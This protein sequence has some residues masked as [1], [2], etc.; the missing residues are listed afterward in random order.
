MNKI[1]VITLLAL[2]SACT[3]G[4][5]YQAPDISL[6]ES[7]FSYGIDKPKIDTKEAVEQE[8]WHHFNDPVLDKLI[9]KANADN[10]DLKI[11]TARIAESR[12]GRAHSI[13]DFLPTG[14][15][16]ASGLREGNQIAFPQPIAGLQKPF[17]TFQTGFDA[18]WE[19]DVFGKKKRALE[20]SSAEL[21]SAEATA[22]DARISIL[23]EVA[24]TYIDIRGY[25]ENLAITAENISAAQKTVDI[26]GEQY[27]AGKISQL[28]LTQAKAQL[29]QA[30]TQLPYYQNLLAQAEY[31]MDLLLGEQPNF[32]HQ[33]LVGNKSIPVFDKQ[34]VLSAPAKIIANRPDI[35]IAE[36]NLAAATANQGVAI[37]QFF[38]DISLSGFIG[39][40]NVDAGNMLKTSSKSWNAGGNILLPILNYGKLSANLDATDAKQ[41]QELANYQK[42]IISA[43]SDVAKSMTAYSNQEKLREDLIK[44]V[45]E[46]QKTT[47]IA[48]KR[49][50][51]GASSFTDVLEAKR[52]L[53]AAEIQ[54]VQ[55]NAKAAQNLIAV[56]KSLGG[57]WKNTEPV[58]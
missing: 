24:R 47:A 11:A 26:I 27:R 50:N 16:M 41:Q 5:D 18:S 40:L 2:L 56:Y 49:Y 1:I 6:A 22:D 57:G 37:A 13:A 17:N 14:G 38:P 3:V 45:T 43:L 19:L 20:A 53:Y 25:Q 46:N 58:K 35:K 30:K 33:M 44:A 54:L 10:L 42:S 8:W 32:T 55:A 51:E 39:L 4:S 15:L 7:W 9:T 52:N 21:E 29:D 31:S 28:N 34:I 12:A 36:R 48:N 23:A